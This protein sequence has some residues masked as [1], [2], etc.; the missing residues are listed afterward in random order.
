MQVT[1]EAAETKTHREIHSLWGVFA[2]T[3][4][5]VLVHLV[6]FFSGVWD[7]AEA[8]RQIDRRVHWDALKTSTEKEMKKGVEVSPTKLSKCQIW[9]LPVPHAMLLHI[10][11]ISQYT[12]YIN[13][14][15][16]AYIFNSH[17][18]VESCR[19]MRTCGIMWHVC[20]IKKIWG[21]VAG[22]PEPLD[23]QQPLLGTSGGVRFAA[24]A[25]VVPLHA[26]LWS[27]ARWQVTGWFRA[28][29]YRWIWGDAIRQLHDTV[30]P[31]TTWYYIHVNHVT[32]SLHYCF[33]L[34]HM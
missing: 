14:H 4:R 15:D 26:L 13:L 25:L 24:V 16:Y 10:I 30:L 33:L 18:H 34:L 32:F 21:A 7:L 2:T 11:I 27:C 9:M 28:A 3:H 23:G 5:I 22:D 29:G 20:G 31:D 12:L 19:I 1:L 17:M 8:G 6:L